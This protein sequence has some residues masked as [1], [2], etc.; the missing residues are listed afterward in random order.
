MP[1]SSVRMLA[2][3][4]SSAELSA[5]LVDGCTVSFVALQPMIRIRNKS[6]ISFFIRVD[7]NGENKTISVFAFKIIRLPIRRPISDLKW[8]CCV[9]RTLC[10][11]P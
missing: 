2:V 8:N 11:C 6:G 9:S 7:C 4:A 1:F 10:K 3:A 5:S